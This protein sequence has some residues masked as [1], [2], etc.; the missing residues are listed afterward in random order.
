MI[1]VVVK[2]PGMTKNAYQCDLVAYEQ[3]RAKVDIW[4][5]KDD[6]LTLEIDFLRCVNRNI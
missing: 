3:S 4:R 6:I 2:K 1:V 5:G